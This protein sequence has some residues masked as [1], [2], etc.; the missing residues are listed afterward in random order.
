MPAF[1]KSKDEWRSM[2]EVFGDRIM[3]QRALKG[4]T[5]IVL[6]NKL[7]LSRGTVYKYECGTFLPCLLTLVKLADVLNVTTDYLVGREEAA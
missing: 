5:Q 6:A 3:K 2:A 1:D 7:N 4:M